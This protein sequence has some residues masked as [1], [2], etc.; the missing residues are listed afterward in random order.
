[1]LARLRNTTVKT[2]LD[3]PAGLDEFAAA[4]KPRRKGAVKV[5]LHTRHSFR[6]IH[7]QLP[8]AAICWVRARMDGTDW[9]DPTQLQGPFLNEWPLLFYRQLVWQRVQALYGGKMPGQ[10]NMSGI[11]ASLTRQIA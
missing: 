9:H 5:R 4:S 7:W 3:W 2:A 8:Y 6:E 10:R 11:S 1:L